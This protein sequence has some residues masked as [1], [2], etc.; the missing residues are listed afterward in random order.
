MS[1]GYKWR[2]DNWVLEQP[3]KEQIK[4]FWEWCGFTLRCPPEKDAYGRGIW[5]YPEGTYGNLELD[6][7]NLF[8]YAVPKLRDNYQYELIGWNEGQHK[9]IINKLQKGWAE[10]YTTA[11]D[12]DPALALFWAIWEVMENGTD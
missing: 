7:N 6:L 2:P 3:T 4:E 12:K 8:K 9:A 10:T 5:N 1:S 11:I